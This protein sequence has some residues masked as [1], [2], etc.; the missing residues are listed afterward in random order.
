MGWQGGVLVAL[1]SSLVA[2]L[3]SLWRQRGAATAP[4]V[5]VRH[6]LK[7]VAGLFRS[8]WWTIG[9]VAAAIAWLLHIGALAIAPLSIVQASL[10]AGFVFLALL[11]DRFFGFDL[12]VR[13][14]V[15]VA[16]ASAGL[17]FLAL[18]AGDVHGT[19]SSYAVPSMIAFEAGMV[20]VG[21]LL[22]LSSS[23]GERVRDRSGVLLGAGAGALFTATHVALKALTHHF[24]G[25]I[26]LI[27][28]WTPIVVAG[29]VVAFFASARSLQIGPAVPVIAVTSIVGNATSIAAGV[30]VFGDPLGEG[31]MVVARVAAFVVVVIVAAL[32]PGPIHAARERKL[33]RR[34]TVGAP[35]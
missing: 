4:E 31:P 22:I 8:K 28:P 24:D 12:G 10:A 13:E 5:D 35:A 3:G 34:G 27:S 17:A 6:P 11:A 7:T 2:N 15:G 30:V 19:Q 29:G 32:L 23:G 14:W 25:P 26:S 16:L 20:A 9:Y 1:G 18:S 21:A 33:S